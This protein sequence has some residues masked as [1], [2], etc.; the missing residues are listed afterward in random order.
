MIRKLICCS[1]STTILTLVEARW[2]WWIFSFLGMEKYYIRNRTQDCFLMMMI[3]ICALVLPV[4]VMGS[5]HKLDIMVNIR[6]SLDIAETVSST[7]LEGSFYFANFFCDILQV[8]LQTSLIKCILQQDFECRLTG[9]KRTVFLTTLDR[10]STRLNSSHT[11]ISYAV[12]CLKKK[13]NKK[14]ITVMY[15]RQLQT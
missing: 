1:Q 14:T 4:F 8:L 15:T 5:P 7:K 6:H 10:K 2:T 3:R 13:K 11:V 12:F 9:A